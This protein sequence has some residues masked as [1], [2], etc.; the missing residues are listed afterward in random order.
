MSYKLV[1][2]G[3]DLSLNFL[4]GIVKFRFSALTDNVY[5]SDL[6]GNSFFEFIGDKLYVTMDGVRKLEFVKTK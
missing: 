1:V 4:V 6:H 5:V 3:N 2:K